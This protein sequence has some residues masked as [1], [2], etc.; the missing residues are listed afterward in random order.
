MNRISSI[1]PLIL[2]LTVPTACAPPES[3]PVET[4]ETAGTPAG[5]FAG[6]SPSAELPPEPIG[7][8]EVVPL[9]ELVDSS[10]IEQRAGE[11]RWEYVQRGSADLDGD[12]QPELVVV[13]ARAELVRGV[14]AW[15]DGQPWQIYV[16]EPGG[17][18][19]HFYAGYVQ[20]GTILTRITLP[21]EDAETA[22]I[23]MLEHLPDRISLY[24]ARYLGPGEAE[25]RRIYQRDLDPMGEL[26]SPLMP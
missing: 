9:S 26:A 5:S 16:E 22:R 10:Y 15:D 23:M 18:R 6:T 7:P 12:G 17:E 11:D 19:T 25:V 1:V 2:I 14:P 4:P 20:L 24:E 8:G 13:T 3:S 21:P